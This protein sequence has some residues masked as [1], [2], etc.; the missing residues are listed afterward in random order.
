MLGKFMASR[1]HPTLNRLAFSGPSW[2]S[3]DKKKLPERLPKAVTLGRVASYTDLELNFDVFDEARISREFLPDFKA[4][5]TWVSTLLY[6][7]HHLPRVSCGGEV[8]LRLF[9]SY[10]N[11]FDSP[12][13]LIAKQNWFQSQCSKISLVL[14]SG[15]DGSPNEDSLSRARILG[16]WT[17]DVGWQV[18]EEIIRSLRAEIL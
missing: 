2:G 14:Y 13:R 7:E 9:F 6:R 16:V 18:E 8:H 11:T 10:V 15:G 3:A 17:K 12:K 4:Y 5:S 1:Y